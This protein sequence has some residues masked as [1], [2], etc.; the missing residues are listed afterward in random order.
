[1][2]GDIGIPTR[3]A[4]DA[5]NA[6][7]STAF[8]TAAVG[9]IV[10]PS[11]VPSGAAMVFYQAAAPVGWTSVALNDRALRVVSAGGT[12]GTGGG[13]NA[14]STVFAQTVV[15]NHS[16]STAELPSHTHGFTASVSNATIFP[17]TGCSPTTVGAAVSAGTTGSAGSGTAHNHSI[18]MSITFS[19]VIVCTKN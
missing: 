16:L 19:D 1:M 8:V 18:T 14:F 4:G 15:G 12:G 13:S 3:P 7:A 17:V 6:A 2:N 9:A 11:P 10:F 5:T